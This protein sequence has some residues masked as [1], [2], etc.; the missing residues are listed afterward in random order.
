METTHLWMNL[1][2]AV[3]ELLDAG[4]DPGEV[5]DAVDD[6]CEKYGKEDNIARAPKPKKK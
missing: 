2:S 6:Y 5:I 1:E 3:N 4:E